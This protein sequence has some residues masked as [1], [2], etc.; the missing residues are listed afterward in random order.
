[1]VAFRRSTVPSS[2]VLAAQRGDGKALDALVHETMPLVYNIVGR[3]LRGHSDV[4]DLVQETMLGIVR[5][6]PGLR[7]PDAFRSW[8]V[9]LTVRQLRWHYGE[10]STAEHSRSLDESVEPADPQADFVDVSIIR[11]GLTGQRREAVEAT[12]WL[13]PDDRELLSLWWL[14]AAGTLTRSELA[15]A[16]DLPNTHAAVRV[17]R[18]RQQLDTARTV[19]RAL[20]QTPGCAGLGSLTASWDG[21]PSPLWRK[22]LGRHIRECADCQS[23]GRDL[24]PANGLLVGMA[25][26]PLPPSLG[27]ASAATASATA[28]FNHRRRGSR[29]P[30]LRTTL[31]SSIAAVVVVATGA[32][33]A[34]GGHPTTPTAHTLPMAAAPA[35]PS[36]RPSARPGTPAA[37]PGHRTPTPSRTAP[38]GAATNTTTTTVAKKGDAVWSFDGI[39]TALTASGASWYYTWGPNHQGIASPHGLQFVPMVWGAASVTASTLATVREQGATDLLGFNEPDMASQSNMTPQQALSLW[40][41]LMATGLTLGSPAVAANGAVP[42]GWLDRFMQGARARG[43]R[44]DFIAL[45]WYGSDFRTADAVSQLQGYLQAVHARYGLPIWLTEY[46]LTSYTPSGP[47]FPSLPQQAAFVTASTTMLQSLPYVERYAWFALPATT[48]GATGL[49]APGGAPTLL[50]TAYAAAGR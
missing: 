38:A 44:V 45:H 16:L 7:D 29:R 43:Y 22:R 13:D 47:S 41:H 17:Q 15:A 32:L 35:A 20:Q 50:G 21:V 8:A 2:T 3:A 31:G 23:C 4:D 26:V 25:L 1:M 14:E 33:A 40:P 48:P 24:V 28:G 39:G 46:A 27:G 30:S 19:V 18:M 11:L 36:A 42:G 9:A 37:S 5:G 6:L 49:Y 12:R 34:T 10:R